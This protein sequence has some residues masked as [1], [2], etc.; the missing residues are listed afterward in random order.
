MFNHRINDDLHLR[1]LED[2]D[3]ADVFAAVD[4]N[5]EHLRR[6]MPWVSDG[7]SLDDARSFQRRSLEQFA[8]NDGFQAGIFRSG[9]LA[10]VIGFHAIDWPNRRTTIG[11]WLDAAHVGRGIMSAA[12]AAMV[13]HALTVWKLNRVEVRC[14]T[15]ND[16]SRRIPERLGF[17]LEGVARDAEWIFDHFVDHAIYAVLAREWP[18]RSS[19][20][21]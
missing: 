1:L 3:A 14:A 4:R 16:R 18:G 5:R 17:T 20:N 15:G 12:C 10:G 13:D 21:H 11:Y 2:R 6:W 19:V 8:R 9:Q 7:Y